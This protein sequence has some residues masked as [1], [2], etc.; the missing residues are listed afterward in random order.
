M[1]P[2]RSLGPALVS[3]HL[4]EAWVYVVG[5]LAGALLAVGIDKFLALGA[6]AEAGE[7]S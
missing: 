4:T 1:N 5:P 6:A 7:T 3:G 2:A